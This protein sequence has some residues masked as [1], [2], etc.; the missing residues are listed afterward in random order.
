LEETTQQNAILVEQSAV[1]SDS[2]KSQATNLAKA[3]D[4]F[5]IG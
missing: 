5:K 3:V 4:Y 2:L 1:T